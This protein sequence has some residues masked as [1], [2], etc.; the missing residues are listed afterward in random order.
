M[1]NNYSFGTSGPILYDLALIYLKAPTFLQI[2]EITC[3]KIP[4]RLLYGANFGAPE[5]LGAVSAT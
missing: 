1:P 3:K 2:P 4:T 5:F